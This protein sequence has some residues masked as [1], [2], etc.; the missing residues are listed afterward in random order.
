[1]NVNNELNLIVNQIGY[2]C[3]QRI[4]KMVDLIVEVY[5]IETNINKCNLILQLIEIR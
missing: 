3:K 5:V 1:M 2:D 4:N